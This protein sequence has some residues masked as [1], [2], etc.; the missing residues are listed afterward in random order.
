MCI[1][2]RAYRDKDYQL[3]YDAATEAIRLNHLNK[4]Y[5]GNRAAAALKLRGQSHL[6]QAVDD[7][8]LAC[9]LEPTYVKGF[10]RSHQWQT[11]DRGSA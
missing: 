3:C 8:K 9:A 1:R 11:R 6:R 5:Y 10:V 7:C 2:D 4:A